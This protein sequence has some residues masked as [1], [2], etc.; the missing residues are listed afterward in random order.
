M[1]RRRYLMCR[2]TYFEVSYAINPWMDPNTPVDG[3]TALAQ[4]DELKTIYE[5]LGH[6]VELIDPLPGQPDMV[7][8]ANGALVVGGK[9]FGAAFKN[10]ERADEAP[11]FRSWFAGAGFIDIHTP[12]NV[13]EGEGDFAVVGDAVLA[14]TGFRTDHGAHLEAQEFLGRPVTSLQLVD[15]HFYHLDTALF[16]LDDTNVA[17]YPA[18]FS[19]GS[20]A[21]LRQLFPDAVIATEADAYAFGLNSVSD[22]R[23]VVVE[24]G[25]ADLIAALGEHG[26]E[27]LP[28]DMS[29][30]RKSGGGPKCCTQ[31]IR[32]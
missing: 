11:A 20:Q 5:R 19:E 18:A 23:H 31:E 27:A 4:W 24:S 15:P 2:P 26:Y 22:G 1:P 3:A 21:V 10:P 32:V 14:G 16:V 28:I 13:N 8:A 7:F 12:K 30:L 6:T 9:V 29:E 17:Y 25:A